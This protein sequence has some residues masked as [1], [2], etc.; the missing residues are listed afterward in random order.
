MVTNPNSLW[1]PAPLGVP[2]LSDPTDPLGVPPAHLVQSE[3]L[4]PGSGPNRSPGIPAEN[5]NSPS[6]SKKTS[7]NNNKRSNSKSKSKL[8]RVRYF[9]HPEEP[10][11]G[12]ILSDSLTDGQDNNNTLSL[13]QPQV[14]TKFLYRPLQTIKNV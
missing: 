12:Q 2:P 3:A 1:T 6:N 11:V 4:S 8:S 14:R 10:P 7:K 9:L 5:H 13:K